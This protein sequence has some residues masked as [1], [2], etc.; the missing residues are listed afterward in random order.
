MALDSK[1]FEPRLRSSFALK[2]AQNV[3]ETTSRLPCA[4]SLPSD[5]AGFERASGDVRPRRD[6]R[7][8]GPARPLAAAGRA[9]CSQ[10]RLI[11]TPAHSPTYRSPVRDRQKKQNNSG[12]PAP[13]LSDL[14]RQMTPDG[15]RRPGI[16]IPRRV[17]ALNLRAAT[18]NRTEP[19]RRLRLKAGLRVR[20]L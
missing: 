16:G 9:T 11:A 1:S 20:S 7:G 5:T 18:D 4:R 19:A 12:Q 15:R 2:T 17:H 3:G 6:S 10:A 13:N 14:S 8:A